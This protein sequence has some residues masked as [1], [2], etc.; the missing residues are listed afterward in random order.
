MPKRVLSVI[1]S[2]IWLSALYDVTKSMQHLSHGSQCVKGATRWK[3]EPHVSDGG[4]KHTARY[5]NNVIFHLLCERL[6]SIS[7]NRSQHWE[8][9]KFDSAASTGQKRTTTSWSKSRRNQPS[10]PRRQSPRPR[11]RQDPFLIMFVPPHDFQGTNKKD[12]KHA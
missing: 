7:G 3:V 4:C 2:A 6:L 12:I 10:L 8:P 9:E 11:C 1:L 5:A